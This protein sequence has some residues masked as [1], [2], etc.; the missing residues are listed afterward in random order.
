M[1][2]RLRLLGALVALLPSLAWG[3]VTSPPVSVLN[4]GGGGGGGGLSPTLTSAHIFVGNGSNVATDVAMSGDCA[5]ANTGAITCTKS[6]GTS[7]G[8]AA[9]QN[10]G[11]SGANV[12]LL[13]TANT[14]G[15]VQTLPNGAA[16]GPSINFGEATTGFY[17]FANNVIGI[18]INGTVQSKF[19]GNSGLVFAGQFGIAGGGSG[20]NNPTFRLYA[21]SATAAN[22]VL[23]LDN[24]SS[25]SVNFGACAN[26]VFC[27]N[28]ALMTGSSTALTLTS[29]AV[30]MTKIAASGSAPGAAGGK[31]ELVCGTGAGS[32]KL[33]I[34][35]GTS[36]TA[37]TVV[38][39]IGSGVTGC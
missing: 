24:N 5:M 12:P 10:T 7:F 29:G 17:R 27:E 35:A 4:G 28:G 2:P 13:S 31:L 32:A 30:G 20:A 38:D 3:Q 1:R 25:N 19:D 37:V 14:W 33:I 8:T 22:G 9:F 23:T 16:N 34:S 18:T 36:A 21:S 39:N 6:N 11:T 26:G 15:G